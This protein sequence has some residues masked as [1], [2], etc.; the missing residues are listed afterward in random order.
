MVGSLGMTAK[1][2]V[3]GKRRPVPDYVPAQ[4]SRSGVSVMIPLSPEIVASLQEH[5]T[6]GM[7]L[8]AM[9]SD[10]ATVEPGELIATLKAAA[11]ALKRDH[12]KVSAALKKRKLKR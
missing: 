1:K 6:S 5:V 9:L 8:Y 4:P 12:A 7:K 11:A 2:A 10:V 3:L